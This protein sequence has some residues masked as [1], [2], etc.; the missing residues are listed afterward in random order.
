MTSSQN[1]EIR[2]NLVERYNFERLYLLNEKKIILNSVWISLKRKW[3]AF[4]KNYYE[5][6][7][8][9]S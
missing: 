5:K 1:V 7:N 2:K 3:S 4:V 8:P 6:S 9:E